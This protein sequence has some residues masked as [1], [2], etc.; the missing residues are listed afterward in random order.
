VNKDEARKVALEQSRALREMS[1]AQL[2]E[3]YLNESETVEVT[4]PSGTVYQV[5]TRAFWD[6]RKEEGLRVSVA[7]DDGGWRAFSPLTEDFIL[8]PDGSFEDE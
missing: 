7:V 3:R 2:R 6:G 1:W 8:A 4:G 5:Q